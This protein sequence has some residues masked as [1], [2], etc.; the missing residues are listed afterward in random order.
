MKTS[1]KLAALTLAAGYTCVAF[2]EFVGAQLPVSLSFE[3]TFGVFV[4]VLV[5]LT[6][7]ADY[8]R[9]T[10]F[11]KLAA[12]RVSTRHGSRPHETHRLAA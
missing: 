1:L 4:A 5:G 9:R 2:A 3:N 10:R 6:F 11:A 7:A 12:E 8:S